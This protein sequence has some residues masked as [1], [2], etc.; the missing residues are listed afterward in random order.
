[1]K[2]WRWTTIWMIAFSAGILFREYSFCEHNHVFWCD[3][4]CCPDCPDLVDYAD[5]EPYVALAIEVRDSVWWDLIIEADPC[6]DS[7]QAWKDQ[8][9]QLW[10]LT[11]EASC[12]D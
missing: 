1:M 6:A 5:V 7:A 8:V 2:W 10:F 11:Q 3:V 12:T 9:D 4:P